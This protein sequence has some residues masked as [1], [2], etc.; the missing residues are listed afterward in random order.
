MTAETPGSGESQVTGSGT[1]GTGMSPVP[2]AGAQVTGQGTQGSTGSST[3]AGAAGAGTELQAAGVVPAQSL[4]SGTG[5]AEEQQTAVVVSQSVVSGCRRPKWSQGILR[6]ERDAGEPKKILRRGKAPERLSC[7][8]ASAASST[9][10]ESSSSVRAVDQR[11]WR[12]AVMEYDS[13]MRGGVQEVVPR[14][15]RESRLTSR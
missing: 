11:G 8:V 15:E 1:Q 9:H 7:Y 4:S 10:S 2:G 14:P 6:D 13:V 3:G 12:D 5:H